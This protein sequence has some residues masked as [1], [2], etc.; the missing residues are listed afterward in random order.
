[1]EDLPV[2]TCWGKFPQPV[3]VLFG[4][5]DDRL[6]VDSENF[7]LERFLGTILGPLK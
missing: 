5:V 3:V 7:I 1:M 6:E 4:A 2:R